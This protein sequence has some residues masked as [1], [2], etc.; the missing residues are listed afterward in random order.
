[1]VGAAVVVGGTAEA[2]VVGGAAVGGAAVTDVT[3]EVLEP[4][5]ATV[6][7]VVRV[8]AVLVGAAFEAEQAPRST[9][10]SAEA[11]SAR[12]NRAPP[13]LRSPTTEGFRS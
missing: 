8:L 10:G 7:A 12:A 1:V 11:V 2:V 5:P 4:P 9:H 3:T 6:L 13:W